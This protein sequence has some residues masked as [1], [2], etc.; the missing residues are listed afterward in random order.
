V[1]EVDHRHLPCRIIWRKE[2][3]IGVHFEA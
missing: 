2:K 3:R 1:V